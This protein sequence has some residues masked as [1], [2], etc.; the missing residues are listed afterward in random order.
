MA[1]QG[2]NAPSH[3]AAAVT[4]GGPN[5]EEVSHC[6]SSAAL[7]A[8]FT[9]VVASLSVVSTG[10]AVL[11]SG[12]APRVSVPALELMREGDSAVT[13]VPVSKGSAQA[14]RIRHV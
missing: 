1:K 13:S 8:S 9:A 5:K 6:S 10:V 11:M 14:A 2:I 12:E 3:S 4:S 7:S